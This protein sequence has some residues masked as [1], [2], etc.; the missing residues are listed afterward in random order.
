MTKAADVIAATALT[1]DYN[2]FFGLQSPGLSGPN[3]L[4]F[5][6]PE[7]TQNTAFCFERRILTGPETHC[8]EGAQPTLQSPHLGFCDPDLG[9]V[10][11]VGI[12]DEPIAD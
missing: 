8:I 4:L 10:I 6:S 2:A 9:A 3:T 5:E 7:D 11:G 12:D 1:V